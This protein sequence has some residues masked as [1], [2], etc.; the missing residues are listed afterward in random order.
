MTQSP[1][2]EREGADVPPFGPFSAPEP[3][4]DLLLVDLLTLGLLAGF[5]GGLGLAALVAF[6]ARAAS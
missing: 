2:A 4:S 5:L 1:S 3:V 6:I